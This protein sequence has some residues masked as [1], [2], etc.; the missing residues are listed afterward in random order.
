MSIL[1]ELTALITGL[2]LRVETGVFKGKAPEE[3][4]VITPIIDTFEVWADN[5][6]YF[7]VQEARLSLFSKTNYQAQKNK[8]VKALL[9]QDFT[10]TERR[11]IGHED[12]TEY[13]HFSIDTA[14]AYDLKEANM[15]GDDWSG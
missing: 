14:K 3:Y 13:H 9:Q 1:A 11:Y 5:Q 6:P 10:I 7:E 4:V 8:V 2:G 12:D 15:D